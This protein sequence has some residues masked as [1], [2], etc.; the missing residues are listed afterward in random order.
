MGA[1]VKEPLAIDSQHV[2]Q[3]RRQSGGPIRSAAQ[4][5]VL[6]Q[7]ERSELDPAAIELLDRHLSCRVPVVCID[8]LFDSVSYFEPRPFEPYLVQ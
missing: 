8:W 7:Q 2:K 3:K 1:Q 5:V 4:Q 6:M